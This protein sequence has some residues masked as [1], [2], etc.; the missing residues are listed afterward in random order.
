MPPPPHQDRT[1]G[2]RRP[3]SKAGGAERL[4]AGFEI[5]AMPFG[6]VGAIPRQ[7]HLDG[8]AQ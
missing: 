1:A 2:V 7:G 5:A 8:A 4:G 6:L 3:R